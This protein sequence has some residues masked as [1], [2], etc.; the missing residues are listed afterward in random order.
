VEALSQ[1]ASAQNAKTIILPSDVTA[2]IGGLS[3]AL[4][5]LREK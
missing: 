4:E 5:V 1:V 3:A 2:A